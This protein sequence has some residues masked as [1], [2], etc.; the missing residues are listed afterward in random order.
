[1]IG[2]IVRIFLVT[3]FLCWVAFALGLIAQLLIYFFKLGL[4]FTTL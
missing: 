3:L 1:M 2:R 4:H